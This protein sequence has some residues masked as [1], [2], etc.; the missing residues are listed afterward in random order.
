MEFL[1]S[2]SNVTMCLLAV[3]LHGGVGGSASNSSWHSCSLSAKGMSSSPAQGPG[4]ESPREAVVFCGI[5]STASAPGE[6]WRGK[7]S[8]QLGPSAAHQLTQLVWEGKRRKSW[9]HQ[10]TAG[11]CL[12]WWVHQLTCWWFWCGTAAREVREVEKEA[13][14]FK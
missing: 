8:L 10:F 2:G 1:C 7:A 11:L 12:P 5:T 3:D 9:V 14:Y 13:L 4:S 6:L